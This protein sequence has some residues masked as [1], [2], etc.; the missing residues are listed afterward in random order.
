MLL[1]ACKFALPERLGGSEPKA[2]EGLTP[3]EV[4]VTTLP[5]PGAEPEKTPATE[6]Q[7]GEDPDRSESETPAQTEDD[8]PTPPVIKSAAQIACEKGGGN[9]I[10]LDKSNVMTCQKPT[11]DAGKQCLRET[12]C[13]GACL[14]RSNSCAPAKPLFGCNDVL[15]ADG[16]RTTLCIE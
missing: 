5:E 9:F 16:R 10:H 3:H 4:T 2:V 6:D 1:A 15:E 13:E 8:P 12:D 11:R 14:A 7:E